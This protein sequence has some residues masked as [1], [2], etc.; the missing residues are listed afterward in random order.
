MNSDKRIQFSAKTLVKEVYLALLERK[1]Q[2]Q[3]GA[4]WAVWTQETNYRG[5]RRAPGAKEKASQRLH[6]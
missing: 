4:S 5:K 1:S 3:K 6:A 2:R